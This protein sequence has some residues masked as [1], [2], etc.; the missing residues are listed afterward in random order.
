MKDNIRT[1]LL[2]SATRSVP[3]LVLPSDPNLMFLSEIIINNV[4]SVVT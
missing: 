1:D 2:V 3:Q 4:I